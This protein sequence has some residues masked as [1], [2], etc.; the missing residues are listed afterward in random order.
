[1]GLR[2]GALI[3]AAGFGTRLQPLTHCT[4]KCLVPVAGLPLLE[5]TLRSLEACHIEQILINTHH[6]AEKVQEY[7]EKRDSKAEIKVLY[8]AEIMGT[9]GTLLEARNYLDAQDQLLVMNADILSCYPLQRVLEADRKGKGQL[10]ARNEEV[11]SYLLFNKE[12]HFTGLSLPDGSL[13]EYQ[14]SESKELLHYLGVHTVPVQL[15]HELP[16]MST[17][18]T[19]WS[20]YEPLVRSG[21]QF[22]LH[23]VPG[24]YYW[25]DVGTLAAL[26]AAR[27]FFS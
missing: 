12:G 7:L 15:L 13:I 25:S 4:P 21:F 10:L 27:R 11:S 14:V 24:A 6:L 16:A 8:E 2:Y 17:P 26:N 19:L 9:G 23:R 18:C 5:Y 3:M 1:M 22:H 20:V